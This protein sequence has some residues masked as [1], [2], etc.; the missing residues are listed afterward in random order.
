[1]TAAQSILYVG[2]RSGTCEQ[3]A[4]A[5]TELGRRLTHIEAELPL[6]R[7]PRY[8]AYWL[9]HHFSRPPDVF[10]ANSKIKREFRR[11]ETDILWIDKGRSIR[12]GTL[13]RVRRRSPAAK[14]V[15]YSADNMFNEHNRSHR[16]LRGIPLYDL[17]VTT[18]SFSVDVLREAGAAR[19]LCVDK[20]FDP[21][22]HRPL[23]LTAS[24]RERYDSDIGFIGV[25]EREIADLLYGLA[26]AGLRVVVWGAY[27]D[28]YPRAHPRLELR[29]EWLS[30]LDYSKAINATRINLGLLRKSS[31]DLHTARSIEI[32]ACRAFMLG[33]RTDEHVR[34]FE[35][36]EEAEFFSSFEELLSK[37]RYYLAHDVERRRIAEGGYRRCIEGRYDVH[38]RL[39]TILE[40]IERV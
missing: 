23:E 28:R 6:R 15:L 17:H 32:P 37:C 24:E 12:P 7:D 22:T 19:V 34:L 5:L 20:A 35:E 14:F 2:P 3:R 9:G 38:S 16:F 11:G 36:G 25:Y 40:E 8:L 4:R 39:T 29:N 21:K 18:K 10:A 30:G 27:W 31:G 26:E 13:R 1:M 33:K